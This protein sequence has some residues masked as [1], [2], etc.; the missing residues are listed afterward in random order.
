VLTGNNKVTIN[1]VFA[2]FASQENLWFKLQLQT[3]TR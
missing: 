3:Y 2:V 1:V